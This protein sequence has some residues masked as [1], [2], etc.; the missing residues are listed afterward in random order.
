[1]YSPRFTKLKSFGSKFFIVQMFIHTTLD[2]N[3]TV[4]IW[5]LWWQCV[6]DC[7][8]TDPTTVV[9]GVQKYV[10]AV[11]LLF[12]PDL[13]QQELISIDVVGPRTIEAN[14]RLGGYG[15]ILFITSINWSLVNVAFY[16]SISWVCIR[17]MTFS[18]YYRTCMASSAENKSFCEV[19]KH[20]IN[21]KVSLPKV[22]EIHGWIVKIDEIVHT[23]K[24]SS[25][26]CELFHKNI[27]STKITLFLNL[28]H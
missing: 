4:K 6:A 21:T 19:P 10:A 20:V 11:K 18:I 13:S 27:L 28:K 23:Y 7:R 14:W 16:I 24:T 3:L 25:S 22:N 8:F 1:M 9:T 5:Y 2:E 17:V 12:D 15:H 26:Y